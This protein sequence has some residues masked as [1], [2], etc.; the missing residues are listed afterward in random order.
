[1]PIISF[2]VK[3]DFGS[4]ITVNGLG[5]FLMFRIP[6]F[7]PFYQI[8]TSPCLT[9]VLWLILVLQLFYETLNM[10][11]KAIK[12]SVYIGPSS[13]VKALCG[14]SVSLNMYYLN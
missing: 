8:A 11:Y 13:K 9:F 4:L 14:H 10:Y 2:C 6:V 1:M 7:P 3:R 5:Y 12:L